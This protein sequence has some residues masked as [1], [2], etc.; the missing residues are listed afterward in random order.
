MWSFAISFVISS[1]RRT[2]GARCSIQHY[3][4]DKEPRETFEE[5]V[6]EKYS[7]VIL[8]NNCQV[9]TE[10]RSKGNCVLVDVVTTDQVFVASFVTGNRFDQSSKV[11]VCFS[12]RFFCGKTPLWNFGGKNLIKNFIFFLTKFQI[13]GRESDFLSG[14]ILIF[15]LF[16]GFIDRKEDEREGVGVYSTNWAK[17]NFLG[18]KIQ[19]FWWENSEFLVGKFRVSGGKIQSFWWENS[20]FWGEKNPGTL[21]KGQSLF[22][23]AALPTE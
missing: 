8:Y 22:T 7:C 19:S 3:R 18:G 4:D 6:T 1:S 13:F 14:N 20:E 16:N 15:G 17:Q 9:K 23:S 21:Q 12:F 11:T 5:V 10:K 2:R